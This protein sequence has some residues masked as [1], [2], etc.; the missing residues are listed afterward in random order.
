MLIRLNPLSRYIGETP[1]FFAP[2]TR[3]LASG[4]KQELERIFKVISDAG[5][6]LNVQDVYLKS[7]ISQRQLMMILSSRCPQLIEATFMLL[8]FNRQPFRVQSDKYSFWLFALTRHPEL[9]PVL[10]SELHWSYQSDLTDVLREIRVY[11]QYY[12]RPKRTQRH[13]GYRDQGSMQPEQ[14]RLRQS[15]LT[16]YYAEQAEQLA[17]TD[18]EFRDAVELMVGM[19]Q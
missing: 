7:P 17:R 14:T 6:N 8:E 18:R 4:E 10:Q 12:R 9:L 11:I 3:P 19:I 5:S 13:K 1:E 15:C 16:D 2:G